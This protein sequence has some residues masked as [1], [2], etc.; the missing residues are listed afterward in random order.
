MYHK[1]IRMRIFLV[2]LF[3]FASQLPAQILGT[4]ASLNP[5]DCQ[6]ARELLESYRNNV[7]VQAVSATTLFPDMIELGMWEEAE[8]IL[9]QVT[10]PLA[11]A[12]WYY[13]HNDFFKAEDYVSQVLENRPD[14]KEALLLRAGLHIQAWELSKALEITSQLLRES[15]EDAEAM[16]LR[17]DVFV[18]Q[19]RYDE[20]MDIARLVQ[21]KAP[22]FAPA[23]RLEAD[24]HFWLLDIQQAEENLRRCLRLDPFNADARFSYGYA[25]WRRV[26]AQQL[27]QMAAQW[28]LALAIHPLHYRTHWHWGN[29]HTHLTYI[30][31][32]DPDEEAIREQLLSADSLLNQHEIDAA[33]RQTR[34]TAQYFPRSVIPLLYRAS[35]FYDT[36]EKSG[37]LDSAHQVF[38]EILERKPHYGP[39]HN[40]LAAVIKAKRFPYLS[41][42]DSLQQVIDQTEISDGKTFRKVFP[43]MNY[44]PGE[45]VPKMLWSQL[46]SARAYFPMLARLDRSFAI[47]P[48][49][50]DL[51][52]AMK[53]DYFRGATTFD[54]RQWMDIR[55]V[56][57]GATGIEYVQRGSHLERNVTL[58][59]YVHLFHSVLFTDEENRQ[60]RKLYYQAME[61]DLI[62]DYYS[63]NNE[64]E[65]FAQTYPA[66]FSPVKVHPLNHKSVNTRGE[67]QRKDP[68]MFAF[69]DQ[70]AQRQD[71][72]LAGD[73][74]ALPE[75]WAETYLQLSRR[76]ALPDSLAWSYLDTAL[77]WAPEYLPA[78]IAMS[79]WYGK[80]GQFPLADQWLEQVYILYPNH[81]SYYLGKARLAYH[82]TKRDL[83][84]P[85]EY[86]SQTIDYYQQALASETDYMERARLSEQLILHYW[87]NGLPDSAVITANQYALQGPEISTYLRD[88][89]DRILALSFYIAGQDTLNETITSFYE[90]LI[91]RK[92]QTY[93]FRKQYAQLLIRHKQYRKA[94]EIME[95]AQEILE[96]S[97]SS[98][99]PFLTAL[100]EAYASIG[101]DRK[102]KNYLELAHRSGSS[103]DR[104]D[105]MDKVR[106]AILLEAYLDAEQLLTETQQQYQPLTP[107]FIADMRYTQGLSMMS[108]NK[109]QKAMEF[110]RQALEIYPG[111]ARAKAQLEK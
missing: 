111:H 83:L 9:D 30:D 69:I 1:F 86:L 13:L 7:R 15:S 70:L 4:N 47:P 50:R 56:G 32:A 51:A 91:S 20:A 74:T 76:S 21:E 36:P 43:D 5:D 63:A 49:H 67:L 48:L 104:Y 80:Q 75:N 97:G 34:T 106:V 77:Q 105:P 65:Y 95:P 29:G 18:L 12:T 64:M 44:Y 88:A 17:G 45:R 87:D 92:P 8:S 11:L 40:G 46:H 2:V 71:A 22:E 24:I 37:H 78:M 52:L 35:Y 103:I 90:A 42:Y 31:Y 89:K 79:N 25:I 85:R 58:H 19:K 27:G 81:P 28:E 54:N 33:I 100:A 38:V 62:L 60:V 98:R 73:S 10:D 108:L 101:Y 3:G 6:A 14:H 59:E 99:S 53:S 57:S 23:F 68:E 72:F 102:A 39:A 96:A 84:T 55:G 61:E 82:R 109:D 93:D 66:Y 110:F 26:D 94:I 107:R 41:Q 16:V